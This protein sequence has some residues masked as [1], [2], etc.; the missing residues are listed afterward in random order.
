[1]IIYE[2]EIAKEIAKI[3]NISEEELEKYI[4]IPP[5]SQM[6]DYAFPCFRLAKTLKKAPPMIAAEIKEKLTLDPELFEKMEVDGRI[7]KL[8]YQ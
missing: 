8:L 5:D 4:E 3:T 6:G 7:F 1:M 2:K